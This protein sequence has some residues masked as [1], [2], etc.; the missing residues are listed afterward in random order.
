MSRNSFTRYDRQLLRVTPIDKLHRWVRQGE[1]P[2]RAREGPLGDDSVAQ[3]FGLVATD[4]T[5]EL[6]LSTDF[7]VGCDDLGA[8]YLNHLLIAKTQGGH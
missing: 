7:T 4:G 5:Y 1:L 6:N 2:V 8:P 3:L